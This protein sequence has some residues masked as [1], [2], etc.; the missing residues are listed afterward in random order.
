M[1][2]RRFD[3]AR[4][5]IATAHGM[6]GRNGVFDKFQIETHEAKLIWTEAL[7][8]GLSADLKEEQRAQGLLEA[9]LARKADDLYHPV[10]TM[11]LLADLSERYQTSADHGQKK[12]LKALVDRALKVV[13]NLPANFSQSH[14]H[15]LPIR[16]GLARSS[17]ILREN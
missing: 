14:P 13:K 6:A 10:S 4:R 7:H 16:E 8:K 9:I 15:I 1:N 2:F 5:Y 12:A 3:S 11:R 17:Q